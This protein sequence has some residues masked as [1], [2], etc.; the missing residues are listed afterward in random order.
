[1]LPPPYPA[2]GWISGKCYHHLTQH[3]GEFQG[4]NWEML[5]PPYPAFGW[6]SGV[7]LRNVTTSLPSIWVNFKSLTV[8]CY[9]LLPQHVGEFQGFSGG[10]LGNSKLILLLIFQQQQVG[11]S[12]V[13]WN[14]QEF[15][16]QFRNKPAGGIINCCAQSW[17]THQGQINQIDHSTRLP[18]GNLGSMMYVYNRCSKHG[19]HGR[20]IHW[21]QTVVYLTC[22]PHVESLCNMLATVMMLASDIFMET[23]GV[24]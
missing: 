8:K 16:S 22:R 2:F 3:L 21:W 11:L 10:M 17:S 18:A 24:S 20:L 12:K 6:I 14:I 7:W 13:A 1:M 5:P 9:H 15:L 23:M 19:G 4:S